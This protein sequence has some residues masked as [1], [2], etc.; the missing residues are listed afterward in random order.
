M[1]TAYLLFVGELPPLFSPVLERLRDAGCEVRH[2]A[3]YSDALFA[4]KRQP[5]VLSKTML[6]WGSARN[7]IPEISAGCGSLF[8]YFPVEDGCWWIP[9]MLQGQPCETKAALHSRDF[10]KLL[11]ETFNNTNDCLMER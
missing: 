3:D 11:L 6:P 7:L 10:A 2:A 4:I 5:I 1:L 9:M 8:V